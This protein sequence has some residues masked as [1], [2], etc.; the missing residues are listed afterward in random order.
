[1][2]EIIWREM[3]KADINKVVKLEQESFA[4]PWSEQAFREELVNDKAVYL[5]GWQ[6]D[7]VAAYAGMWL[8]V[9]EANITNV[10]VAAGLRGKGIGTELMR[11]MIKA[12]AER[13]AVAM[14]L[15]VR[16]SNRAALALYNKLGFVIAGR[17]KNYYEDNHED[18]LILWLK[19]AAFS[20]QAGGK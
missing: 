13:A 14:T 9:D 5:L 10:A 6:E 17:R 3:G 15:E 1:M 2:T 20:N 12:A 18:A 7:K 16:P 4:I 19:D 8:V 11:Q